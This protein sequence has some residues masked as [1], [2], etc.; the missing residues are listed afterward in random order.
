MSAQ[1]DRLC[2]ALA[3]VGED[4]PLRRFLTLTDRQAEAVADDAAKWCELFAESNVVFLD[5]GRMPESAF[6]ITPELL[7]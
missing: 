2:R 3:L 6:R 1:D 4:K 5:D 7:L